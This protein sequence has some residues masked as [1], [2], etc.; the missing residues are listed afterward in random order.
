[1]F[2]KSIESEHNILFIFETKDGYKIE[3]V[4][5]K[6]PGCLCISTHVGCKI[7][8][9]FCASS[10]KGCIRALT[11]DELVEQINCV[12]EKQGKLN[13]VHFGGIGEPAN[14]LS[15]VFSAMEKV[16]D[17]V[18]TFSLTTSIP[19]IESFKKIV[20]A[21]FSGI[22]VSMHSV[23]ND[24]RKQIM[25]NALPATNVIDILKKMVKEYPD[26]S[27]K[28]TMGYIVLSGINDSDE[29]IREF[30]NLSK[31]LNCTLFPMYYNKIEE[32]SF[33]RTDEKKY[34]EI[35]ELLKSENVKFSKSSGSRRDSI[36]GCGTLRVNRETKE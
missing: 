33:L 15:N 32:N 24:T 23:N 6:K 12:Y 22:A 29:E 11:L 27:Q 14:N 9:I 2:L 4:L 20:E 28:L 30:V 31:M 34:S 13:D 1:M 36:G 18:N 10:K 16:K 8:C 21:N 17:K 19:S 26:L 3:A 25:P 35:L 7:D 5:A